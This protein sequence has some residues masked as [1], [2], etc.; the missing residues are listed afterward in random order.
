MCFNKELTVF[1]ASISVLLGLWVTQGK[2]IWDIGLWRRRR[3]SAVFFWFAIMEF[4]QFVDYLVIND[5][6]NS[7]N[8]FWT[9]LGWIHVCFQP[10]FSNLA[11]SAL[12]RGN[13]EK[14]REEAWMF[15]V[16]FCFVCGCLSA[17][18]I[19][20][21]AI[22][23]L[24]DDGKGFYTTI[25]T[26]GMEGICGPKTCS[27]SGLF[28]I[29]WTFRMLR[30]SYAIPGFA[31]HALTMFTAPFLMGQWLATTALFFSGPFLTL[32]FDGIKDGE[33][34][35]IWCFFSIVEAATTV[36]TQYLAVRET[37]KKEVKDGLRVTPTPEK[38]K[39]TA[40]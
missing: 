12:D 4:I 40:K 6:T 19:I 39:Q 21:P 31:I 32:F 24:P 8:T 5:C 38:G 30:P 28:H 16:R 2:G 26:E 11:L 25:C 14:K 20:I 13:V 15:I 27:Q 3:I 10:L 36:T 29:Q 35:A 18:R 9:A 22:F 7:V 1:F 37:L 23:D 17:S 33:T 34:A